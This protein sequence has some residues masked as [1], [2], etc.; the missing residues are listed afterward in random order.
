MTG[1]WSRW[2]EEY[3]DPASPM[4]RRL[5]ITQE[6]TRQAI[7]ACPAGPIRLISICAG[8]GRDVLGA[9][10]GHPRQADVAAVLLELDPAGVDLARR[11]TQ[12]ANLTNVT[13]VQTDASLSDAYGAFV[14]ADVLLICGVFGN[15]SDRDIRH[16]VEYL[17]RLCR[18]AAI[19]IWTRYLGVPGRFPD[20]TPSIRAWLRSADFDEL[21]FD[22][23]T[24]RWGIGTH[25]LAGPPLPYQPGV[26]IFSFLDPELR[27]RRPSS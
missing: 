18:P 25:R 10:D 4:A 14:P 12:A 26:R 23:T 13:V 24:R 11:R 3:D 16:T 7:A 19:V 6:A 27:W 9:L 17:P 21:A 8:Q 5:A 15:I 2:H 22:T 1:F 20:L